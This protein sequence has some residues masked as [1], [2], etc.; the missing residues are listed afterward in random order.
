MQSLFGLKVRIRPRYF[1]NESIFTL[2]KL[3][4]QVL[5]DDGLAIVVFDTDV[6]TCNESENK[7]LAA[8]RQRYSKH[9]RVILCDS[10]PSIEFWFLIH[11][12]NTNRYFGTSKAVIDELI[13]FIS[14]FDKCESFLSNKK[15]VEELSQ[16]GKF[17]DACTRA[18][19]IGPNGDSYSNLWKAFE[20]LGVFV[21]KELE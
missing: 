20:Y 1:G 2:E 8:L 4:K 10:M 19:Q 7:K 9:K 3:I 17:N 12:I 6:S 15:W 18:K 5:D 14:K 16:D 13:K 21:T 11:F